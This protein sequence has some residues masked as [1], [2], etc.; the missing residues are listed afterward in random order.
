MS[1]YVF[2]LSNIN[3]SVR[4][5]VRVCVHACESMGECSATDPLCCI[6]ARPAHAEVAVV[7]HQGTLPRSQQVNP[8]HLHTQPLLG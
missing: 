6:A 1:V 3:V 7:L 5:C 2:V 8:P 4:V